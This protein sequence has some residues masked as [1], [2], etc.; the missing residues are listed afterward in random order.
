LSFSNL[1]LSD[2]EVMT[3][4]GYKMTKTGRRE[5]VTKERRYVNI[6]DCNRNK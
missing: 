2:F 4:K 3:E 6:S 1:S 5:L